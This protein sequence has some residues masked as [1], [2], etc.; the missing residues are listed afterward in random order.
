[1]LGHSVNS[2]N[3]QDNGLYFRLINNLIVNANFFFT[4]LLFIINFLFLTLLIY[5]T[6]YRQKLFRSFAKCLTVFMNSDL[7][8]II[9]KIKR[10]K[11]RG[12]ILF[13]LII[14]WILIRFFK[15]IFSNNIHLDQVIV[16]TSSI[17][18]TEEDIFKS[19]RLLCWLRGEKDIFFFR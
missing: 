9:I 15:E 12:K 5:L 13:T 16:D 10:Q 17:I 8:I 2:D 18:K 1:M 19:K 6:N 3:G 4:S 7:M 11:F 14:T